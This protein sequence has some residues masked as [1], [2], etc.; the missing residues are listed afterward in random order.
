VG[1]ANVC[2]PTL[3]GLATNFGLQ[4]LLSRSVAV[5]SDARMSGRTD[6]AIVTEWLLSIS[7]EDQIT[8]DRKHLSSVTGKLPTRFVILTNELP[9]MSDASG[10]LASRFIILRL[11]RSFYGQEDTALTEK[12]LAERP[13]ILFWAIEGW[14]RLQDRGQF[15]QPISSEEL[16]RD[17]EDLSSPVGAFVR[18]CCE[19]G[20][21]H[22]VVVDD[23][24]QRWQ[25]WCDQQ[26]RKEPGTKQTFARDLRAQVP[27]IEPH[28]PTGEHGARVRKYMGIDLKAPDLGEYE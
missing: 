2:N 17:M 3:G 26:G 1:Q 4:P 10:A 5:I 7:G 8:V 6:S 9:R 16:I 20:P 25:W 12:L 27:G 28:R 23:I 24:Y 13:G 11:T 22:E 14:R 21:G 19:V 15:V 18:D